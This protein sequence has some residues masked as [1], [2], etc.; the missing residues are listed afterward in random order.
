MISYQEQEQIK[1][2]TVGLF[3]FTVSS[4]RG[5]HNGRRNVVSG[6]W[7]SK[8]R[9]HIFNHEQEVEKEKTRRRVGLWTLKA[10]PQ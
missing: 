2:E 6:R 7:I 8:L 5:G 3:G 10:H 9:H 1:A 4:W